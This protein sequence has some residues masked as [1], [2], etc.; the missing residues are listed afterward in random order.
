MNILDSARLLLA[1]GW[2][3][4]PPSFFLPALV[5]PAAATRLRL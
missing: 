3:D 5:H 1:P 4:F 2:F